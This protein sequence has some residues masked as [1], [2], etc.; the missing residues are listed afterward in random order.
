MISFA[1]WLLQ[2]TSLV[3]PAVID[4]YEREFHRQLEGLIA[5]T[6]DPGLRQAFEAMRQFRFVNYIVGAMIRHGIPQQYDVE[7]SLQR[8][9]FRMLSPVGDFGLLLMSAAAARGASLTR[10]YSTWT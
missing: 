9:V 3:D 7:D 6:R 8:M 10:V 2:E 1:E 5:R 4:S